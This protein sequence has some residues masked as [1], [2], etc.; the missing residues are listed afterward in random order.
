MTV[1]WFGN[2]I[3]ERVKQAAMRGVVR[4]TTEVK[5]DAINSMRNSPPTGREY[6]RRGVTHIASS[7]G[8]PPRPDTGTLIGRTRMEFVYDQLLGRVIFSTNY[9]AALEY[10]TERMEPRPYAR[11]ALARNKR[12]IESLVN[13]EIRAELAR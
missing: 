3:K 12:K 9:A 6:T 8:N 2:E 10:G 7:P 4:A 13:Q 11:P 1:K 5:A